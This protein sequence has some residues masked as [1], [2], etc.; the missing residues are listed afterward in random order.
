MTKNENQE[1]LAVNYREWKS[2]TYIFVGF[3]IFLLFGIFILYETFI[4]SEKDLGS[5]FFFTGW[6]SLIILMILITPK[7]IEIDDNELTI[8]WIGR[9]SIFIKNSVNR[10]SKFKYPA[11]IYF[12]RIIENNER[13]RFHVFE[14]LPILVNYELEPYYKLEPGRI[15]NVVEEIDKWVCNNLDHNNA[16]APDAKSRGV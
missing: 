2:P 12:F 8:T 3:I 9:K 11:M 1:E 16:S 6:V 10:I 7:R 15:Y 5:I 14:K 4:D 13:Q